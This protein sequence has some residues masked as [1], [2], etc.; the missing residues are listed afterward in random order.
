MRNTE[1]G[2]VF[3][4][5]SPGTATKPATGPIPNG[6]RVIWAEPN[7]EAWRTERP[8]TLLLF[9]SPWKISRK[10]SS[11]NSLLAVTAHE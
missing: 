11:G 9:T 6:T 1:T 4:Y 2:A 3:I 10:I 7:G 5:R 8:G